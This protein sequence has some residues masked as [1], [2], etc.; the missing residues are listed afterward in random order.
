MCVSVC[1][2][3]LCMRAGNQ[4]LMVIINLSDDV[5]SMQTQ[6]HCRIF[7]IPSTERAIRMEIISLPNRLTSLSIAY[8]NKQCVGLVNVS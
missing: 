6:A 3:V 8:D 5:S 2:C 4:E 1:V 7:I